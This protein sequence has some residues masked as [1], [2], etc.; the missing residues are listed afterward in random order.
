MSKLPKASLCRAASSQASFSV[1]GFPY[2]SSSRQYL[3]SPSHVQ[4]LYYSLRVQLLTLQGTY[5]LQRRKREGGHGNKTSVDAPDWLLCFLRQKQLKAGFIQAHSL[6][7]YG[8]LW[9]GEPNAGA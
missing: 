5:G 1:N 9:W 4:T 2:F 8:P 6:R 3:P 7:G